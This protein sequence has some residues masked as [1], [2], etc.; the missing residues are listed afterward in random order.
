MLMQMRISTFGLPFIRGV[1]RLL[2]IFIFSH[3]TAQVSLLDT[4]ING[5]YQN[6]PLKV[7]L[8]DIESQSGI[9]FSYSA[10]RIPVSERISLRSDN[11]PLHE[12]LS[13]ISTELPL[14]YEVLDNYI[15]LKKGPVQKEGTNKP[16]EIKKVTLSGFIKDEGSG[17]FLIGCALYIKETELG[18]ITN[19]YGFF[20]LTLPPGKY[21]LLI[22]YI[23]FQDKEQTID[24]FGNTNL[25]VKLSSQIEELE[26]VVVTSIR[27]EEQIFNL[28]ASQAEL[29]PAEVKQQPAIMGESDVIKTLEMQ[30]GINFYGDA[31][32]YFH[33]RGGNYDQNLILLD[34][35]TIYNPSHMLGIFSPIIPDAIKRVDIYKSDFPV[36]FGGRLSSVVDIHT[37]DGNKKKFTFSGYAGIISMRGTVE[38]PLKKD[39]SSFFVSFRRSYFDVFLKPFNPNLDK[40]HFYDFTT[41]FNIRMGP[42]DRLFV[43][44]YKGEDIFRS[45]SSNDSSGINWG[46]TSA[47]VRWNHIF[48]SR[49]FLNSTLYTSKYDYYLHSN[50]SQG[51]YWNSRIANTS[52]KE[53]LSFYVTPKL[54]LKTGIKLGVY[55][56]NPGNYYNP[57]NPENL[58]V[59][60]V[61]SLE[62]AAYAGIN[63]QLLNW[64]KLHYGIRLTSW[65]NYGPSFVYKYNQYHEPLW[66]DSIPEG[67]S[68]YSHTGV[69][70]RI[71]VSIRTGKFSS[72]K[73][74]YDRMYQF[75]NLITN[76]ISP[77]NSLEVWMPSGPNIRP[78]Y[79]DMVDMG[80]LHSFWQGALT[81]R[82]DI[83]YKWMYNQIGYAYHADMLVNPEIEGELRQGKGWS[84]GFELALKKEGKK[85]NGE[86]AYTF[87]RSFLLIEELNAGRSFPSTQ[88]RPH[89]LN[90]TLS[91]QLRPRWQLAANY[92]IGSGAKITTPTSFY[93]YRGYQVPVYTRQNNDR[94]PVYRRFDFSST[95]QLNRQPG[96]FNHSLIFALYNMTGRENPIFLYFSKTMTP[97]NTLVVPTDRHN[98]AKQ[99]SSVR[100]AFKVLPSLTYQFNF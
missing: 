30:P 85:L 95:W 70:P 68:Y 43:T 98:M 83:F 13:L 3:V 79:A 12:V 25:N 81:L 15:I 18:A 49:V 14:R 28:R 26:E 42:K 77:L 37:R 82:T 89:T 59:S 41:K 44:F 92:A 6:Q 53:E 80:Y 11:L 73:L 34:E 38:G 86:I 2:F 62:A 71:S 64:L 16:I 75:I 74:S 56:F 36:N 1:F 7:I 54:K 23:G 88:D 32:S 72:I 69:E 90:L 78:Q 39:A 17:E 97:E 100:Y 94:L 65:S 9:H 50:L 40:L 76:S 46:N 5:D 61:R 91:Y 4:R 87:T 48:G 60:P 29:L 19:N 33:V 93:S 66:I 20:S 63:H 8:D 67:E 99:T 31:S 45:Y 52:L 84:Y 10:K 58:Q 21:T 47:T 96:R 55:D 35:A 27:K 51:E 22:S 57:S 24:L